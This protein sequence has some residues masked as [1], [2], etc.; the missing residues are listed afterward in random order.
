[1]AKATELKYTDNELAAIETLRAN[2]GNPMSAAELGIAVAVLTS[3]S[4]KAEKFPEAE[5]VVRNNKEQ[6]TDVCPTCGSK[7]TYNKYVIAEQE[8]EECSND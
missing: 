8:Q 7:H 4:K 1:M 6:V 3:I 2:A 5:G